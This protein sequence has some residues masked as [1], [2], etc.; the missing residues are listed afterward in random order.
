MHLRQLATVCVVLASLQGPASLAQQPAPGECASI[1]GT[2]L[3]EGEMA[4]TGIA[5]RPVYYLEQIEDGLSKK[6]GHYF[7]F[8]LVNPGPTIQVTMFRADRRQ[9]LQ[10]SFG[11]QYVCKNGI[12]LAES[13]VSGGSEGCSKTGRI[14]A[15]L[16]LAPDGSLSF[17]TEEEWEYGFFCFAKPSHTR[18]TV[19]FKP[20]RQQVQ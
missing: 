7:T 1:G 12:F 19:N 9:L 6:E 11:A 5:S 13:E 2:F 17:A 10:R 14:K 15:T 3:V 20:Y 8:S 4:Q 18:R 16:G